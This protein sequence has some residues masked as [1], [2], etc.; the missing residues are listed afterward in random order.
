MPVSHSP[1]PGC[2]ASPGMGMTPPPWPVTWP[3]W[4]A[5]GLLA[6]WTPTGRRTRSGIPV[7]CL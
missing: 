2:R 6:C 7:G 4:W 5:P 1:A 3:R